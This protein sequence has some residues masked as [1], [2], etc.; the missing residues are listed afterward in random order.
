M[1]RLPDSAVSQE[2]AKTKGIVSPIAGRADIFIVPD[3]EAGKMLAKQ[4][5]PCEG[6]RDRARG[7]RAELRAGN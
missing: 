5:I 6:L 4:R 1:V 2:A 7:T 3:L